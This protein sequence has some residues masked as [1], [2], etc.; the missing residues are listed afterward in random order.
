MR[1]IKDR[2]IAVAPESEG[3]KLFY[4]NVI[5]PF[6]RLLRKCIGLVG[7]RRGI[8]LNTNAI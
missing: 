6:P 5:R 3:R 4:Q 1:V 8:G 2:Q 7:V